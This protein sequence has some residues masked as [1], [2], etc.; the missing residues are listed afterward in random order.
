MIQ[1]RPMTAE[2]ALTKLAALCAKAEYC[3]GDMD[4]KMRRW[5]LSDEDRKH[6]ID[7]LI[8]HQYISDERYCRAFVSDKIN[9][10]HWGRRKIE[11][12]LWMKHVDAKVAEAALDEIP[13]ERYIAVLQP[14]LKAKWPTIN[15]NSDYE[16][17]MK[18][19][20]F[21]MGRGFSIDIIKK[22]MEGL[23]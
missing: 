10:N 3:A 2:K 21:A 4:E 14:L 11:Q 19:I 17:S 7:Y 5:G 9:Y 15:A 22:A 18:L 12:A 1:K 13:D 16:R 23:E 8:E 6:N 20:K